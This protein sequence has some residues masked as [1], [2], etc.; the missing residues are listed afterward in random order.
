[1]VSLT[2]NFWSGSGYFASW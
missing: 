1:C 2:D